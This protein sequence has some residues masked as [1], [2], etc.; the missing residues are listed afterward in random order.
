MYC[1]INKFFSQKAKKHKNIPKFGIHS[2]GVILFATC[3]IQFN[4]NGLNPDGSFT[5]YDSN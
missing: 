1:F 5:V 2:I 3:S 4:L